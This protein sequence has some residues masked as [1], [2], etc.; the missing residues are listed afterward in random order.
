MRDQAG[1]RL[2]WAQVAVAALVLVVMGAGGTYL[3]VRQSSPAAADKQ[4]AAPAGGVRITPPVTGPESPV[5]TS[6]A[7]SG[8]GP[9]PDVTITL[10]RDAVQRAGIEVAT[11]GAVGSSSRLRVPAVVQPNA[12]K[13]VLVTPVASGRVTRVLVALGQR[14]TRGQPLVDIYSA[15]LVEAQTR[16]LSARAELDAHERELRRTEKLVEIGAA[17]RRELEQV[18][19][20]HTAAT[21][22]I[23]STRSR[24]SLL[25]LSEPQMTRLTPS[26]DVRATMTVAAP[27]SGVVTERHANTGLNVDPSTPLFTVVDLATVWIVGDVYERDFRRVKLGSAAS[28]T[29]TVY[30]DLV[31]DGRVSYIG[32]QVNPDTRTAEVR[33]EVN[34]RRGDL[35]LGMYAEMDIGEPGQ[36]A[37]T[38]VPR[39]AVQMVGD[40]TVVYVVNPKRPDRFV[41]REIQVGESAGEQVEVIGGVQPGDTIVVRG[42]FPIR[43]ERERLGLRPPAA[44]AAPGGAT[45]SPSEEGLR[46]TVSDQGYAPARVSVQAGKGARITFVRTS[47]A[48]CGTEVVIPALNIKRVL[49]LNQPVTVEL[50]PQKAGDVEF[51]CGMGMLRGTIVVQ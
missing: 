44:A 45:V 50:T 17:S 1:V 14:V 12:Y 13:A 32:P 26:A 5:V 22:T 29:T 46:V 4:T 37:R 19:A 21:A 15:D 3:I 9:L 18:H 49:P 24:L 48:N 34:N 8:S 33:V 7:A 42:S 28:I 35:R 6:V 11:V 16:Y 30:P 47:D 38:V 40:R 39:T 25:G 23:E 51:A 41:E 20:Q 27:V 2:G 36:K 43:A 31:L 10:S